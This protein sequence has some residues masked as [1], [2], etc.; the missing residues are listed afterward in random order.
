MAFNPDDKIQ[1]ENF[2]P[3]LQKLL[4]KKIKEGGGGMP[5]FENSLS[6][7]EINELAD[8]LVTLK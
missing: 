5:A 2:S 6:E 7:E 1:W 8:W 3:T 4:E